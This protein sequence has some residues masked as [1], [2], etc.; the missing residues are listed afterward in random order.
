MG[1]R[2]RPDSDG[3]E[4]KGE[5]HACAR[6]ERESKAAGFALRFRALIAE[7]R[8]EGVSVDDAETG[9]FFKQKLQLA[10]MLETALRT[11]PDYATCE[12]EAI[13][14]RSLGPA[15]VARHFGI[16]NQ[17]GSFYGRRG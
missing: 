11:Q 3:P 13:R 16:K 15:G 10:E 9:W 8:N 12:K 5:V 6:G 7:M 4:A 1:R 2:D 14:R 17:L